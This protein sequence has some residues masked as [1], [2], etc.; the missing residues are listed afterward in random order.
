MINFYFLFYLR[1]VF[2][3]CYLNIW[4]ACIKMIAQCIYT[5]YW[6]AGTNRA[7]E[8]RYMWLF[9]VVLNVARQ[10][11]GSFKVYIAHGAFVIADNRMR[12]VVLFQGGR[13]GITKHTNRTLVDFFAHMRSQVV[14][15]SNLCATLVVTNGTGIWKFFGVSL[16]LVRRL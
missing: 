12:V 13:C 15:V 3:G 8:E 16:N 7:L 10:M 9:M 6:F 11:F 2:G 14:F 1:I 4:M 5:K